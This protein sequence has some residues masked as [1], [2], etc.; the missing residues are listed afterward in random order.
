MLEMVIGVTILAIIA[1][2]LI[3]ATNASSDMTSAGNIQA[4]AMRM[5][6]KAMTRI[7]G[8]LRLSGEQI[9]NGEAFPYV[10]DDGAAAAPFAA[11]SYM[12]APMT[13]LPNEADFG[14]MR[15]I[16]LC[17]PTDLD[18]DGRPEIDANDNGVP[19]L[20][21]DGDGIP[22]DSAADTAGLWD[23]TEASIHPTTRLCWSHS[24][25]AYVVSTGPTGESELVR[26][27]GN[28]VDG[29][30]VLATGVER[31]QFD[32]RA[33]A[34]AA[35]EILPLHCVRVRI[36][37][38]ISDDEGHVYRSSNEAIIRLRNS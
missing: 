5:S 38:R 23:P 1:R 9:V 25:V 7:A 33:S 21:G 10:F 24:T 19:E 20:D 6:E 30:E 12:P 11:Y 14:V 29:R 26:L 36:F 31:I 16:I 32:T 18:G 22:T 2:M 8:D 27:R 17:L 35:G 37:F 15:S 28:G 4:R 34:L 3:G 13:A